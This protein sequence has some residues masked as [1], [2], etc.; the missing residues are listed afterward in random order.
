MELHL[1]YGL[2]C[3]PIL[4]LPEFDFFSGGVQ[5]I[6]KGSSKGYLL[7]ELEAP[8][9]LYRLNMN[10]CRSACMLREI[11]ILCSIQELAMARTGDHV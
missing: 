1:S 2:H 11:S 6:S 7:L 3:F 9:I 10:A 4:S 8:F 5:L